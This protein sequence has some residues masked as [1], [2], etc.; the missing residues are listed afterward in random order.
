M[1]SF[2]NAVDVTFSIKSP[3]ADKPDRYRRRTAST[4]RNTREQTNENNRRK[5]DHDYG[6]YTSAP[7][8][9]QSPIAPARKASTLSSANTSPRKTSTLNTSLPLN[10]STTPGSPSERPNTARSLPAY[11]STHHRGARPSISSTRTRMPK[12]E[13]DTGMNWDGSTN[14]LDRDNMM[15]DMDN[16]ISR[17]RK[18]SC[19]PIKQP[20]HLTLNGS[21][22]ASSRKT[23]HSSHARCRPATQTSGSVVPPPRYA[24]STLPRWQVSTQY[25]SDEDRAR[26][27]HGIDKSSETLYKLFYS[28]SSRP[29]ID[30]VHIDA[31]SP[32]GDAWSYREGSRPATRNEVR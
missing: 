12:Y 25:A 7:F 19:G 8:L 10:V 24:G 22:K 6:M 9:P 18:I 5:S 32:E 14:C 27:Q 15:N 13:D 4:D 30:H 11:N 26:P 23:L 16:E 17:F 31:K 20:P 28:H 1:K 21:H 3:P 29:S 2:N